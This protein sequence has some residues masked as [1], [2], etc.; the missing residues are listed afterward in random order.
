MSRTSARGASLPIFG[1]AKPPTAGVLAS[2]RASL[3]FG[4]VAAVAGAVFAIVAVV[5]VLV[6]KR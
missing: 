4:I 6:L 2:G 1:F 3:P 5:L